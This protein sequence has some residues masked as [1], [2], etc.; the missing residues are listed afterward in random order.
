MQCVMQIRTFARRSVIRVER[1][2]AMCGDLPGLKPLSPTVLCTTARRAT[3]L[4]GLVAAHVHCSNRQ[5]PDK[6]GGVVHG[7]AGTSTRGF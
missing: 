4:G 7:P 2:S 3:Q 6:S 5:G 1:C